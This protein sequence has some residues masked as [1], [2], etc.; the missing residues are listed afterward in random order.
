MSTIPFGNPKEP[1]THKFLCCLYN[2]TEKT[3]LPPNG[4][5]PVEVYNQLG[6]RA[7]EGPVRTRTIDRLVIGC[8][9]NGYVERVGGKIRMTVAGI[10]LCNSIEED[11]RLYCSKVPSYKDWSANIPAF[12]RE[13]K[14]GKRDRCY[15]VISRDTSCRPHEI[16]RLRIRDIIFKTTANNCQYA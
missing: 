7:T 11:S 3:D 1:T 9:R 5:T 13:H 10:R 2:R 12:M 8:E 14:I 16:L 4:L 6:L 15:H